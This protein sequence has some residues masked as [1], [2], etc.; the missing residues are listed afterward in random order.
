MRTDTKLIENIQELKGI[1]P[2]QDWVISVKNQILEREVASVREGFFRSWK[3]PRLV[4]QYRMAFATLVVVGLLIG[5][6]GFAQNSMPGDFL[7]AFK[8][9]TERTKLSLVP[10]K[11]RS[12]LHLEYANENL[13]NIVR[14]VENNRKEKIAPIIEEYQKSVNQAIKNLNENKVDV[15]KIVEKT[16]EINENKQKIEVLASIIIGEDEGLE[17]AL[18]PIY[19]KEVERLIEDL[20]KST[21]LEDQQQC[22]DEATIEYEEENFTQA[23]ELLLNCL[24]EE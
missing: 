15:K 6:F 16:K 13:Q 24:Q 3:L 1:K 7:Y 21:L 22:L 19:K 4:L 17:N 12:L 9:A 20:G 5:T 8:K 14:I 11:E 18:T 2:R 23:L 10:E